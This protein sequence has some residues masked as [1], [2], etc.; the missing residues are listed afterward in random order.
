M[1][2][3]SSLSKNI[4][5]DVIVIGAGITG[6]LVSWH[7]STKGIR[8]VV[9]DKRHVGMGSTAASTSLLQYEIDTP[10][11]ELQKK[12]GIESA[13]KSYLLCRQAIYEL[14]EISRELDT[15]AG[16][17]L[18][19]SL[20]FASVKSHVKNLEKEAQ[21]R[22]S[23]GIELDLLGER[24]IK[25]L[26]HFRKPAALFSKDGGQLD[27]YRLTHA[28]LEAAERKGSS[29]FDHSEV[30]SLHFGRKGV[31]ARVN[32]EWKVRGRKLV[33]AAGYESQNYLPKKIE[34]LVSTFAIISEIFNQREF[35]YQNSMIWETANPYLYIKVT[36]GNR[37]L[38]GGKDVSFYDP[39]KRDK[40]IPAKSKQL[41]LSFHQ[42]FPHLKFK[43]DFK[44]AGT[45][46][47]TKDGLPY[48]GSIPEKPHTYFALGY[49]GNGI[50]FSQIA[51]RIIADH[52]SGCKNG[53]IDLFSFQR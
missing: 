7:L 50:V 47:Y 52:I 3:Y 28:L 23:I 35:W 14:D 12:V 19:P 41:Q 40:L 24:E 36:R 37:I 21:L 49:G 32:K 1:R 20:Q 10:L 51:A 8:S 30:T 53:N 13:N 33:I 31:E 39:V 42:L 2:E 15:D 25:K 46:S 9:L 17:S 27:A 5:T 6:A 26:F 44:W 4:D 11:Y 18:K 16:F 22:K 43:T 34:K 38:I 48:I 29:V 45:F